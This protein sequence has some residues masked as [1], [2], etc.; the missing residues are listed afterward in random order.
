MFKITAAEKRAILRRRIKAAGFE[1]ESYFEVM[2]NFLD[3]VKKNKIK[4]QWKEVYTK[5]Q[6]S[7]K[8]KVS[9]AKENLRSIQNI[10][11]SKD[12]VLWRF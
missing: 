10:G 7:R 2:H 8:G 1:W 9:A 12:I 6:R 11:T 4:V 5:G 3:G